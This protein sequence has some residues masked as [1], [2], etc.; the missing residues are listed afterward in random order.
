MLHSVDGWHW[1]TVHRFDH[2]APADVV[3]YA[4]VPYV[5]TIG[6]DGRG[7]LWGPA[8]PA[9]LEPVARAVVLPPPPSREPVSP[10]DLEALDRALADAVDFR[11]LRERVIPGLERL[12]A[13]GSDEVGTW[14]TERLARRWPVKTVE[15]FADPVP[16]T[17]LLQWYLLRTMGLHRDGA[18][19]IAL[20]NVSFDLEPN[21]AEKYFHPGPGAL[22]VAARIGQDDAETIGAIIEGLGTPGEPAWL[23]GDRIGALSALSGERFGYR[24]EAWRAWWAGRRDDAMVLVPGGVLAMGSEH[25]EPPERPVHRVSVSA[26]LIDRVEVSNAEFERFVA[27]VGHVTDREREKWGWHWTGDWHRVTGADWRH[28]EGPDS[29]LAGRDRHPVVQV[30]WNDARTYC[31][32]RGKRLPTEAEWERAARGAGQ[33]VYAWGDAPPREPDLF[34][35]SYGSDPCC[36]AEDSDGFLTTAPI[37][38]FPAGRSPFGVEDMTGNVWEWTED[39]YDREFYRRS[40]TEDPVNR[41]PGNGFK[42]IRGGGWGNNPN[43]LRTTLRHANRSNAGLSMVGF[44]CARAIGQ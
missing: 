23:D 30:S 6:P 28:P 12:V 10:G 2:A 29:S 32:W 21:R 31:A 43:G 33:R 27:D 19:P 34:R 26:F 41:E 40:P 3:A 13:G 16:M 18:V 22:W 8:P 39:S 17:H 24:I 38:S 35:A 25:G 20:L 4:G 14:L 42:I 15:T 5:G 1:Q 11:D 37:A 36:R 7:G 44:R 9:A